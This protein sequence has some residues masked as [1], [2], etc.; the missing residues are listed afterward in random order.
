M[1]AT[2]SC[3]NRAGASTFWLELPARLCDKARVG[4]NAPRRAGFTL[5]EVLAVSA[6]VG[7]LAA[8]LLPSLSKAREKS[9]AVVC[10][11]NLRQLGQVLQLYQD[12]YRA[13]PSANNSGYF[14]WN[15]NHYVLYGQ[16]LP[17]AGRGLANMFFCPS[18]TIFPR[19]DP[20]TG[21]QNLGVTGAVTAGS[22]YIRGK[23][24]G[25]PHAL[26]GPTVSLMADLFFTSGS[27]RNHAG[28]VNVLFSD[29]AVRF[30]R[31][32]ASWN[33]SQNGAWYDLDQWGL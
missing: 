5:V 17:T 27:A 26:E 31:L 24:D 7:M 1:L 16:L 3:H 19:S 4:K 9:R 2:H 23:T 8:L 15:G 6:I 22:Y 28:G 29:G 18:S 25:A 32:P 12:D 11:N 33:I 21:I 10:V 20:S 30:I 13:L 14:L